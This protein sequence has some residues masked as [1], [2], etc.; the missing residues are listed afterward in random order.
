MSFTDD[1]LKGLEKRSGSTGS[2]K[3]STASNDFTNDF[4]T[5][6]QKR[7]KKKDEEEIAPTLDTLPLRSDDK[8][9]IT[10]YNA[11]DDIA[12]TKE[13]T[14]FD[15][16]AFD[17]GYQFGDVTKTILGTVTDAAENLG[18]GVIGMGEKALDFLAGIA[19]YV[20]QGLYYQNGGG[21][22]IEQD[23]LFRESIEAGKKGLKEF[24][25]KDLYDEEEVAKTIISNPVRNLTGINAETDSVF[26]EKTDALAQS[27]GQLAA[28]AAL[29]AVGVPWWLTTG[30]TS[31]GAETENALKEG[32]TLEEANLSGAISAGAEIL[33]EKISGGIS[34]GG[35]TLDD[36]L[37]KELARGI[38]NKTVRTLAKLGLDM[39]GEGA[40]EVLSGTLGAIG[41]K[42]SYADDKELNELFS[43]EDAFES[44]IGG[45]VLGGVGGSVQAVKSAKD[46]VDY[47]SGLT[48]NEQAVVDKVYKDAVAE[49]EKSG[50]IT[51]KEKSK[52]YD[53]VLE[54]MEKGYISTDTIEEVLG[55]KSSYDSLVKEAEEYDTLY[56]TA[57]GQ[58]SKAQQDRLMELDTKNKANPYKDA[59]KTA[60]DQHSQSV[61]ELVKGDRLSESYNE[62]ARRGKVFEADLTQYDAKQQETIQKA[63]DS[64]ILNNT[65]RTHEFVDII[66]K[67][68]A[69]KGVLFDFT[70]N[71]KLKESGFA[72][73]G[74][75][76]NGYVTKDGITLNIDSPKAWQSTVGHEITHV[77][78]GTDLYTELQ[79]TLFEYAKTKG[80]YQ[81]RYDSLTEL[82]K[83][84]KD[85]NIEAELTADLVGDYLF[86]DKDFINNLSTQ[87]RNIF[88]KIYDE[89]KYLCKVAT[90]GSKEA[91]ELE[92]VRKAFEDAYRADGKAQGD[93]K[94]SISD[95]S[96]KEL[97]KEQQEYFNDSKVRD[98]NG[99]LK[100]M[101]HGSPSAGF[102][103]FDAS[104]S[105][106]DTSLFFTDSD[107]AAASYSGTSEVYEAKT[108]R[109]AGDMNNFLA[110]I[111]Y[112]H[113]EAVEKNGKFELQENGEHVAWSDTAQGIYEEFCWYEGVGEGDAN[114]KVYLNLTNPLEVDAQGRNWDNVTR[115]FSQEIADKYHSLTAEEKA[116]LYDLAQWGEVRMFRHE[117]NKALDIVESRGGGDGYTMRLASA[118][119]KLGED[120]NM[121]DLF[122]IAED[123]FSDLAIEAWAVKQM[124]TRDY[125]QKAKAEGYDGVIFKN[126]VDVGG[127]G[128]DYSPA[129]VAIAF[130]SNQIKS[131]ANVKPTEDP[132]IRFSLSEYTDEQKVEHNKAVVDYFGKTY[133][134]AETGYV[135]LDGTKLDMSGKHDG[136]PGG[137]RTV[138][139][140]D[141]VDALGSD[142]GDG[143]YSGSL[144]QFMSEGNIRISPESDGI[145]LSV[146]PNKAQEMALSSFISRARGEVLLDIDDFN[147]YTVVSVEY[148]RGTHANKVLNDIREWFD[149]GK[150]PTVSNLSQFRS[151]SNKGE[152]TKRY[153]SFYTPAKDLR[154]EVAPVAEE[155]VSKTETVPT[156][157]E[158]VTVP[159]AAGNAAT[160][161][162]YNMRDGENGWGNDYGTAQE[163]LN[164][165]VK[166]VDRGLFDAFINEVEN[167]PQNKQ[168]PS[169]SM[170][171]TDALI[172]VQEDVRQETI[173]PMQGAQLLSEAYSKGGVNALKRL[174]NLSNGNLYPQ[175][176]EK[177]KQYKTVAPVATAENA[178][179]EELF[180]DN[181]SPIQ[182]EL[183][184]L[185]DEQ[186]LIYQELEHAID[187]GS[188]DDVERLAAEY[189]SIAA[190]IREMEAEDAE[191]TGTLNDADAPPEME[192]YPGESNTEVVENPFEGRDWYKV[193]NQ[194]VKAYMYENPEVKPFFQEAALGLMMELNDTT[195][196]EKWYNDEVYYESGGEKGWGGVKRHTSQSI[197]T[198]LDEWHMS[199]ADIEKGLNAIIEDNGAENIAAAKKIEFMLND[200]LLNG[201]KDF[202][203]NKQTPPNQ[204]YLNLLYEKQINEYSRE[205]FDSF[206][207]TADQYAPVE[208]VTEDIAPVVETAP[209]VAPVKEEYEAIKPKPT[210]EPRMARATP[211]EQAAAEILTEEPKVDK[212]KRNL[213][214][215]AKEHVLDSGMVFEDLSLA[216]GNRELQ[217]RWNSIRY[218]DSKAQRLMGNGSEMDNVKSLNAIREEVENTGKVKQF[219]SYLYHK[220]NVD[221]MTLETRYKDVKN[222]PVF[223]NSVTAEESQKVVDMYEAKYPAF[224][225]YANDVYSYMGYLRQ[226]L[227]DGGVISSETAKLWSEMYPNYV[228]I[229]RL[230]DEG[231]NINVPLDTGRTGVN[232]PIKRAKGG[233]RDIL[234]LFDTMG[235]RTMQTYKAIAKNRFGVELK[236]TLGTTIANEFTSVDEAIDSVDTQEGLLQKG[237][238]HKSPTFTVFE[239]GEK[240]TFEI[241]DEM[242]EAM[243]P[244]S[245]MLSSTSKTLNTISNIRRGTLTEYNPWFMLKNAVKDIQ[246]VLINSQHPGKTYANVPRAIKQ[247]A[248]NGH[249]YKEYMENGG[250][251]NSYF[252]SQTNE[253]KEENKA[254]ETAKK[255]F[256]LDAISKANNIIER[257]PRLAEYIASRESGRSVDVAMLD[258]ARVTTNFAAGGDLTKFLNRNGATFLNAS[259]QGAVQQARNI[260]E[261]KMNGLKGWASLAAKYVAAGL[262]AL[263]LNNLIWDDD[264]EYE[265]LSDYVKQD[266]YIVG[267][268]GDGQFVRIPKGRTVAVVQNGFEQMQNLITGNDEA[269]LRTFLDLLVSNLAP[270]NPLDNN[271]LSPVV[272][273]LQN[274]TWY[275]TDLVPTRLQD[276]PAA[277]QYDE[278][279]D[280]ISR[281]L[282]ET[283]DISPY[284]VNYLLDQYSG[285]VGDTFLPMLTPEAE[286]GDNSFL[287]NMI[288]P[289]K[290]MFT[291]DSV[292]NNKNVSN[293]YDLKDEL[294]VTAN[295]SGATEEDILMSKYLNSVSSELSKLYSQKREIQ[296]SSLSDAEKYEKAREIQEQIVSLTK[297]GLG[298]YEDISFEDDYRAGGEYARVGD[299][300]YKLNNDG[301]WQKLSD[302]QL[303]K[304]EATKAAGDSS[305]ATD[306]TN[307]YRWYVP[308]EDAKDATPEWRKITDEQLEKQEEVTRGLGISPEDYWGNKD[309][310]DYAYENPGKYAV[311]K[312]VADDYE[313]Y[314]EYKDICNDFD[315]KDENGETVSGLKKERV[316]NYIFNL[317]IDYGQQAIMFRSMYDSKDDKA[318]YNYDIVEYLNSRDDISYEDTVAILEELGMDVDSEGNV[319]W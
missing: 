81:T 192:V 226:Q 91:R 160:S 221:R 265:E 296:N 134:W 30:A 110:E 22:N 247:M 145:N 97:S 205:A 175:Y 315:A 82:Y 166:N 248:T 303:A 267:K 252:D 276:L 202:Y 181:L 153:G 149:N 284:K 136:A 178:T 295:G 118:Y 87:N 193:G 99:N 242:Y 262:P 237:D 317:D 268:F 49:A 100:V 41:Q 214:T 249:W 172:A 204:D 53:E 310:Y 155:T 131:T 243:K 106:D 176:T 5:G 40:E 300:V 96:G 227:V 150:E 143:S 10:L 316:K 60:K 196:G 102:H 78:E 269:D 187:T 282:G 3:K 46:G 11:S 159:D 133:N 84:V 18:A 184:K 260:R 244:A 57:S 33:T 291:T 186:D 94:Y 312:A 228:P 255:V 21:Y 55:D 171:I 43:S 164:D 90:A 79:N 173:T 299:R 200:R 292:M 203:T 74:K 201:Y 127:Y 198:L 211:A 125:A 314:C 14:W 194:K 72:I 17:D 124:N 138:D 235:Q 112:D 132:D 69:D 253:F 130:D 216:T 289:L 7:K 308:G 36:A 169:G 2:T 256:G 238:K 313:T 89:I 37:T 65:N 38:S 108:I 294:A 258:A 170:P 66:A 4:L 63:I 209:V 85:A 222:K 135:L 86:Q 58:L 148:P 190:K 179:T 1:F 13:R 206:M 183:E 61:F 207:A 298:N 257:L 182:S 15:S 225:D 77:L 212:K 174:V 62:K 93:T 254:L 144:V 24:A 185:Y 215:W 304:Y 92:K 246:D 188:A 105:D 73:D 114:Y 35:K 272:Q 297:E 239:N 107:D 28:T 95:S 54:S 233:N 9:G 165:A 195:K 286:S 42:L 83:D 261:A 161:V 101:Y 283:F 210:K 274:K 20:A 122:S 208:E 98:E 129:T 48:K 167:T 71:T 115:E 109:T 140:R 287:G 104:M 293:F 80:E 266:Y 180:P 113:Y 189:D 158:N 139:H 117:L 218:S 50:K 273:V 306:G 121:Y 271:I 301:E 120:I 68:S 152:Q 197:E 177:A 88:E 146:K 32:A 45:A 191:R 229:R 275:G 223:G 76:V 219:Y 319:T 157:A 305:Y 220:H 137:Y 156:V 213:W 70:N 111:G 19:P 168:L 270:N 288:A 245:D 123:N 290:D 12:P 25:A 16:G 142:Y 151:L 116:T 307:H 318:T 230:G 302:E 234:P 311:S 162:L 236:N 217:A 34:F 126:I 67:I 147:G 163:A 278:S 103:V 128:G 6:V 240:V 26:G 281:W 44:F 232:A 51:E 39:V 23:K 277:E 264:E 280:S 199:Y 250:D 241:T 47:A 31:W 59:L 154:L 224:K 231:L 251:Q 309:E 56:N 263:L 141:I 259:V 119:Q 29:Q 64:G 75:Q 27:A 285:V 279:T 52:I 8:F